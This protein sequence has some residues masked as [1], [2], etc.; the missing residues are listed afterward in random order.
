MVI[1]ILC[2]LAVKYLVKLPEKN[3]VVV[4]FYIVASCEVTLRVAEKIGWV[5]TGCAYNNI[6]FW[7]GNIALSLSLLMYLMQ[8]LSTLHLYLIIKGY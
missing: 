3:N 4:I 1:C 6:S 2:F 8:A 5:I 7:P